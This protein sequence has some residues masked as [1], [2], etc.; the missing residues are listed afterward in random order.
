MPQRQVAAIYNRTIADD[1]WILNDNG[2]FVKR[3]NPEEMH[4]MTIWEWYAENKL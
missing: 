1:K 2:I 3:E 4:Q